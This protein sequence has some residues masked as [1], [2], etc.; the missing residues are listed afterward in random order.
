[1]RASF[2]ANCH[3]TG[4]ATEIIA[5]YGEV[6]APTNRDAHVPV[7]L[8]GVV[9]YLCSRAPGLNTIPVAAKRRGG[10]HGDESVVLNDGVASRCGKG[11]TES[12]PE[13]I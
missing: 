13:R 5:G 1:M 3:R 11:N 12:I 8:D 6:S 10:R 4:R 2:N 7:T 9:H